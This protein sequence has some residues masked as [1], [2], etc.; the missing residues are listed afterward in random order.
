V[1]VENVHGTK[2]LFKNDNASGK[3]SKEKSKL[4]HT[5]VMKCMFLCKR[6]RQDI[7][8]GIEFLSTRVQDPTENDWMKLK[9]IINFLNNT[10]DEVTTMMMN[11]SGEIKWYIDAA[12]TVQK[13]HKSQTGAVCVFGEGSVLSTSVKQKVNSRS[14]TEAEFIAVDNVLS[15]ILWTKLFM[16]HQMN[17]QFKTIIL[18]DNQSSMR[19]ELNG[20]DSSGKHT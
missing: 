15:K 14:S 12:F 17:Q 2:N 9:K 16:D 8:P 11:D 5:F 13:Y 7:Q 10:K 6:G 20:K 1:E 18:Q 4:F 19:L 3:L